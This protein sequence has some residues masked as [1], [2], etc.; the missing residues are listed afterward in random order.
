M[1]NAKPLLS[2]K[3]LD[4]CLNYSPETGIFTWEV[5]PVEHFKNLH[6]QKIFNTQFSNTE[7]G[8]VGGNGYISFKLGGYS[9]YAHRIAWFYI[10]GLWPDQID[11]KNG[12]RSDNRINN[13]RNVTNNRHNQRKPNANNI[14]GYLG[15]SFHKATNKYQ[16][17][18]CI[19]GKRKSL[20]YFTNPEAAHTAYLKAKQEL[21]ETCTI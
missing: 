8:S 17:Q 3:Y 11:H 2:K 7:A 5:R 9:Y 1:K 19:Y 16:A 10:H 12:I 20:G 18:I 14:F 4:E 21:H 15:V 6:G 13:L